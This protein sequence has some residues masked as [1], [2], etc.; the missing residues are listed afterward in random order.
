MIAICIVCV[1]MALVIVLATSIG[2]ETRPTV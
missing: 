2:V 1:I